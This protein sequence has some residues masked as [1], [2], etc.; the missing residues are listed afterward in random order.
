[1]HGT[2]LSN[3][4]LGIKYLIHKN[5]ALT[6]T[7][8]TCIVPSGTDQTVALYENQ[9]FAGLGFMIEEEGADFSFDLNQLPY[10]RQNELFRALTGL[11][12]DLFTLVPTEQELHLN[13]TAEELGVGYYE[14]KAPSLPEGERP[15]A[16]PFG[17]GA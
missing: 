15:Y 6:D 4:L 2:P 13:L 8:L 5:G 12:G 14:Y 11:E 3:T 10:E 16:E 17:E 7:D 1:M 9:G